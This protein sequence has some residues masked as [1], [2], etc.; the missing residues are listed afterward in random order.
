ME[1]K[2]TPKIQFLERAAPPYKKSWPKRSLITLIGMMI[3]LIMGVCAIIVS[4]AFDYY[5]ND[6]IYKE[7]FMALKTILK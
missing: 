3:G 2:D 7:R 6:P 4:Y 1:A 5:S